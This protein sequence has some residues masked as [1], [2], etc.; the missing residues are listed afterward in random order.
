MVIEAENIA[1]PPISCISSRPTPMLLWGNR[2]NSTGFHFWQETEG[3]GKWQRKYK[4]VMTG[5]NNTI[6][7]NYVTS[8]TCKYIYVT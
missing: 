2:D 8:P 5:Q 6:E 4:L 7:W 3:D 1:V